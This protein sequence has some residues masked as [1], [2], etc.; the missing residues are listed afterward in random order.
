[1]TDQHSPELKCPRCGNTQVTPCGESIQ[2][3]SEDYPGQALDEREIKTAAYQCEC[4]VA[5][6]QKSRGG[7][8]KG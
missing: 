5:F 3:R 2:Y 4:G 7:R 1:M 6:T 8:A